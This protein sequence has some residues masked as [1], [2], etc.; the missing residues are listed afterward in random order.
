MLP[1][2]ARAMSSTPQYTLYTLCANAEKTLPSHSMHVNKTKSD[3]AI[4]GIPYTET[5][6]TFAEI[7]GDLA[8]ASGNDK[9][10]VPTLRAGD[11]YVTDSFKIAEWLDARAPTP[12]LFPTRDAHRLARL[13]S[14]WTDGDMA[15]SIR[16]L[17]RPLF[18]DLNDAASKE[19]FVRVRYLGQADELAAHRAALRSL[20][21]VERKAVRARASL[22]VLE[23]YLSHE[24]GPFILGREASHA[25]SIVY[26]WYCC[27]QVNARVVNPRL[28]YH[29][30]LPRVAAWVDAMKARTGLDVSFPTPE[31]Y[32]Y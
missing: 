17:F 24:E 25:D 20:P 27:S 10:T 14:A 31:G 22:A 12:T 13:L 2:L 1:R 15:L 8:R 7:R 23:N 21:D 5:K 9:V 11:E 4:L 6:L 16:E 30:S 32:A 3:L 29:D 19:Y 18:Y 28:W 26:G